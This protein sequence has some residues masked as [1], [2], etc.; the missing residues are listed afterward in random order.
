MSDL[1]PRVVCLMQLPPPVH[2]ASIL[3][4][5]V[6]RSDVL[7]SRF[8]IDVVPMRFSKTL[9]GMVPAWADNH[10]RSSKENPPNTSPVR[11]TAAYLLGLI[12]GLS[13][14]PFPRLTAKLRRAGPLSK[15]KQK[16]ATR[17][18]LKRFVS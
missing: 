2:G 18:R 15:E 4:E 17:R 9:A 14:F 3:S 12:Y 10:P 5:I 1:R 16:R 7:K 11:L 8:T 13:P 6:A